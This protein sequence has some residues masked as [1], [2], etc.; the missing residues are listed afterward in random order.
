MSRQTLHV[1]N[2][3]FQYLLDHSLREH[4]AQA[5]LR[6]ATASHSHAGM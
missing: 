5:A 4:P 3:L 6:Q 1:D 2:P